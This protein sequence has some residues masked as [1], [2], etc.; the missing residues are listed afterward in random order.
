MKL[1]HLK[2]VIAN[3]L[4]IFSI[5]CGCTGQSSQTQEGIKETTLSHN[6]LTPTTVMHTATPTRI[7]TRT[8][9]TIP[10]HTL[11]TDEEIQAW[12]LKNMRTPECDLPCWLGITPGVSTWD[13][14]KERLAP[15]LSQISELELT[16]KLGASVIFQFSTTE[17]PDIVIY[18]GVSIQENIVTSMAISGSWEAGYQLPELLSRYGVPGQ[19]WV[20]GYFDSPIYSG[21]RGI[22]LHLYYPGRNF[23][24]TFSVPP[25]EPIFTDASDW[26]NCITFGPQLSIFEQDEYRNFDD[27]A[28]HLERSSLFPVLPISKALEMSVQTF[29]EV[30]KDATDPICFKTPVELWHWEDTTPSP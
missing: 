8:P 29:Y 20:D 18:L 9:T 19:V 16:G 28:V 6:T 21:P 1:I 11:L 5:L 10:T 26:Q 23:F 4:I 25:T 22:L 30:Y 24:A 7:L 12:L 2:Q 3:S 17:M 13:T 15:Y 27:V 14:T